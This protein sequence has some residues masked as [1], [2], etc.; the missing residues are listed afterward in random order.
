MLK[1]SNSNLYDSDI[2]LYVFSSEANLKLQNIS[3]TL[4]IVKKIITNLDSS[5]ASGSGFVPVVVIK[6]CQLEPSYILTE[7]FSMCLKES[8]FPDCWK[9]SLVVHVFK[10]KKVMKGLLLKTT[11][12]LVFFQWLVK[13][14]K[15]LSAIGLLITYRNAFFWFPV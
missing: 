14:W 3:I 4:K 10:N 2:P 8:C 13:N 6:N 12:L 15:I 5:K 7:L 9:I 11:A 1:T